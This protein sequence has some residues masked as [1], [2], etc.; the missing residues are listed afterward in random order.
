M[1][2][3]PKMKVNYGASPV[4]QIKQTKKSFPDA[5]IGHEPHLVGK[6]L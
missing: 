2:Q 3:I 6:N 5:G 1:G 4:I